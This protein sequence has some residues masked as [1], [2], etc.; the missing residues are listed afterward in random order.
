M[1][2]TDVRQISSG[3]I[4]ISNESISTIRFCTTYKGNLPHY[5]YIF[6]FPEPL[7]AKNKNVA[8]SKLGNMLY[9]G[10]Q[11]GEEAIKV[12]I[13]NCRSEGLKN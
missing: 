6:R 7:G 8:C 2:Q 13:F 3:V 5:S 12:S 9:L 10:I 11:I 1:H 4:N